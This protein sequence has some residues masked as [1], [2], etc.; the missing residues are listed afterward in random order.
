MELQ[1]RKLSLLNSVGKAERVW[2]VRPLRPGAA[3]RM[4]CLGLT[5]HSED[6]IPCG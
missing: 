3:K 5:V 1:A 6:S 4:D 2:K